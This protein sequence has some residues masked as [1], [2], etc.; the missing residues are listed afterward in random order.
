M[1]LKKERYCSK[2]G[3]A[4]YI[5]GT[6]ILASGYICKLNPFRPVVMGLIG[7]CSERKRNKKEQYFKAKG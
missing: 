4:E 6:S 5:N 1:F 7:K 3:F 2:C